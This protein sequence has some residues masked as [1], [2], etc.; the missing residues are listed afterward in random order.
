[1]TP[2]NKMTNTCLYR[3][4]SILTHWYPHP[5]PPWYGL[6]WQQLSLSQWWHGCLLSCS[7]GL[8][9]RDWERECRSDCERVR[10]RDGL[11]A[12]SPSPPAATWARLAALLSLLSSRQAGAGPGSYRHQFIWTEDWWTSAR[13]HTHTFVSNESNKRIVLNKVKGKDIFAAVIIL[14]TD[15]YWLSWCRG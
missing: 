3:R 6:L 15:H 2:T 9:G 12:S 8:R 13:G 1:M 5:K 4:S 11:V 10:D 7:Y 14:R